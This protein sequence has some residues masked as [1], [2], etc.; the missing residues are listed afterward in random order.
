MFLRTLVAYSDVYYDGQSG[1]QDAKGKGYD[2]NFYKGFFLGHIPG[3]DLVYPENNT[4]L[5][6][7]R[8]YKIHEGNSTS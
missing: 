2:S 1:L 4:G 7:V 8:I 6:P 5:A 3:F